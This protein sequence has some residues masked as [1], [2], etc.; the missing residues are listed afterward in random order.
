MN[1]MKKL[2]KEGTVVMMGRIKIWFYKEKGFSGYINRFLLNSQWNRVGIEIDGKIAI[3]DYSR[4][5]IKVTKEQLLSHYPKATFTFMQ[6]PEIEKASWFIDR[7]L[8]KPDD[9][10]ITQYFNKKRV[11]QSDGEWSGSE[12]AAEALRR[13]GANMELPK[14]RVTPGDLWG[15]LPILTFNPRS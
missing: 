11:W 10:S 1:Q 14:Y 2:N 8:T 12:L 15:R 9:P 5:V 4:G 13:A 6:V 7:Q 3:V